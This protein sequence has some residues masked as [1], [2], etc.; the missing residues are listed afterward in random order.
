MEDQIFYEEVTSARTTALFVAL[1]LLFLG[2]AA[3]RA[4]ASGLVFLA[5]A[6]LGAGCFFTFYTFNYRALI[7]RL[8][9]EALVLKFGLCTWTVPLKEIAAC[10][11]DDVSIWRIGGAGIH[12]TSI[13]GRYRA[14]FNVLEYPRVVVALKHRRGPV[15]DVVFSTRQPDRVMGAIAEA[16]GAE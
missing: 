12:F 4:M 5:I 2:L 10:T 16:L 8:T 15:R 1:A 6:L 13:A 9:P 7:I 11:L 3:W 14:M